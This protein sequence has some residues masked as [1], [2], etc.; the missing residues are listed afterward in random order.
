MKRGAALLLAALLVLPGLTACGSDSKKP[1]S[2]DEDAVISGGSGQQGT[3]GSGAETGRPEDGAGDSLTE[4]IQNGVKDAGEDLEDA[5]RD[6]KDEAEDLMED[7][8]RRA[9]L[10]RPHDRDGDLTDHENDSAAPSGTR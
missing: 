8:A 5:A 7:A 3:E 6:A 10:A 1:Q 9:R 4:D 2:G